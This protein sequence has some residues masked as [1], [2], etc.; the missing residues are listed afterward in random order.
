MRLLDSVGTLQL[1]DTGRRCSVRDVRILAV[2]C[3]KGCDGG[4][5][6]LLHDAILA[7]YWQTMKMFGGY[8]S[9]CDP[10]SEW[11]KDPV[12][13]KLRHDAQRSLLGEPPGACVACGQI[14]CTGAAP[15]SGA[16]S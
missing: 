15:P 3:T 9:G 11:N 4:K 8:H 6:Q 13:T 2:H 5:D 14:D 12:G 16:L 7:P 10:D 1:L